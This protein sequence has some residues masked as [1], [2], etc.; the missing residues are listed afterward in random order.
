MSRSRVLAGHISPLDES[1][2]LGRRL[3]VREARNAT[4]LLDDDGTTRRYTDLTSSYGAVNFGHLNPDITAHQGLDADLVSGVYPEE[5]YEVAAWLTDRLGTPDHHVLYQVGGSFAV[6]SALA[7][8]QRVRQ[9]R[10]LVLDGAFH[11]LGVD[12]LAATSTHRQLALHNTPWVTETDR[13]IERVAPGGPVPDLDGI[14][15]LLFEPVQGA[16]GY[17]PVDP[18]WLERLVRAARAQGVVVIADEIQAGFHRHGA[19]SPSRAAGLEPDIHLF[20]KSLTNGLAA[21]SAVVYPKAFDRAVGQDLALAHTFQTSVPAYRAAAA[22]SRWL[23]RTPVAQLTDGVATA[24]EKY[25]KQ[26]SGLYGTRDVHLTGPTLSFGHDRAGELVHRCVER[27]VL[28]FTGGHD[29]R[30]IRVA[31]PLTIP[32]EQLASALDL[33]TEALESLGDTHD[34]QTDEE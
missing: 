13:W 6:A 20:S 34:D 12:T 26:T 30:R 14:S 1:R 23:D 21:L 5:A 9:G 25:A 11:G 22:V 8:A 24:L 15:C 29:G 19:L 18:V 31:P 16:G 17:V 28:V 2:V 27:G 10:I 33:L 32:P 4:L 3:I 7:L